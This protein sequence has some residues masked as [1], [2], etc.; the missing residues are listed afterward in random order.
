MGEHKVGK[1]KEEF[2]QADIPLR[3]LADGHQMPA[4][5]LGTLNLAENELSNIVREAIMHGYRMFDTS[6]VYGNEKAVGKALLECM[7]HGLVKRQELFI[8]SK[9]WITDRNNVEDALK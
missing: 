1:W 7:Q 5:G 4:L 8:V 9:L 3:T 6:P 2:K